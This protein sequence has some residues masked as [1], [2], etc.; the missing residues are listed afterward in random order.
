[1]IPYMKFTMCAC[2]REKERER[3][4]E[5]ER[6]SERDDICQILLLICTFRLLLLWLVPSA[7][8]APATVAQVD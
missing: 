4:R 6:D 8:M 5:R 1:M 3:E 7:A 2:M